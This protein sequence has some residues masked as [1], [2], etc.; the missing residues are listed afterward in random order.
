MYRQAINFYVIKIPASIRLHFRR[1]SAGALS[2]ESRKNVVNPD[3][4][5][6]P[7]AAAADYYYLWDAL[8]EENR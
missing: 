1:G 5:P 7:T 6:R 4:L 3:Y 8:M 2:A